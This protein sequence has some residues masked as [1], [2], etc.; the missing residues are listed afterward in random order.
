[1][2]TTRSALL[3]AAAHRLAVQDH[4]VER[5]ADGRRQAVHDHADAVADQHEVACGSTSR[6]IGVV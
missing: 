1:M 2:S 4:H 5:D 6:A 3:D